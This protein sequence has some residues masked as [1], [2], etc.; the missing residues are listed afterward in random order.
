MDAH[1]RAPPNAECTQT[2]E[3]PQTHRWGL[4]SWRWCSLNGDCLCQAFFRLAPCGRICSHIVMFSS[5]RDG[6]SAI[7]KDY[8]VR[9]LKQ[10]LEALVKKVVAQ[11]Q[12][13]EQ[14]QEDLREICREL[15][16]VEYDVLSRLDVRSLAMLLR[17]S[18]RVEAFGLIIEADAAQLRSQG[19]VASADAL[20]SRAQSLR[21][22][23]G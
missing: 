13:P 5:R 21:E 19:D 3:L 6:P 11:A 23:Q 4:M 2:F 7:E 18:E 1:W 8:L 10:L 16:D 14:S 20:Q 9:Q 12:A 17:T 15:L 22:T